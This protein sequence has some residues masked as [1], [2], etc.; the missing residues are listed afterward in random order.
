MLKVWLALMLG[1]E[2]RLGAGLGLHRAITEFAPAIRPGAGSDLV[3]LNRMRR[4]RKD[5]FYV[6]ARIA[7]IAKSFR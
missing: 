2:S 3:L 7:E 6:I 4:K 1:Q 5:A